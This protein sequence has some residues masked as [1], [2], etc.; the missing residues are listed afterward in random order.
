[1]TNEEKLKSAFVSTFNVASEVIKDELKYRDIP[2][3][4]SLAH[5]KLVAAL[6]EAFDVMFETEQVLDMSS[7]AK[8]RE[9]LAKEHE[10]EF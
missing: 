1:M 6:E 5:M 4:D 10:I 2:Q 7:Y 9:I 3:W 8:A